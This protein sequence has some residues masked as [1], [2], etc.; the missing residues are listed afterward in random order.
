MPRFRVEVGVGCCWLSGSRTCISSCCAGVGG[1]ATG[2]VHLIE[3]VICRVPLKCMRPYTVKKTL[4][5]GREVRASCR[6][7]TT[8]FRS[9]ILDLV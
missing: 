1:I 2:E 7:A 3:V 8:R 9:L 5:Y 6:G 4:K